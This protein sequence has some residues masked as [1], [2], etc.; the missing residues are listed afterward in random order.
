MRVSF[1]F[2]NLKVDS[3][4]IGRAPC[5]MAVCELTIGFSLDTTGKTPGGGN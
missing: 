4:T 1:I 5:T 3:M 2:I